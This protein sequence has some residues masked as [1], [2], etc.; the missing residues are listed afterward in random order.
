P[1]RRRAAPEASRHAQEGRR[2]R[3]PSA[4]HEETTRRR[5]ALTGVFIHPMI[6]ADLAI[7]NTSELLTVRGPAPRRGA[8]Q[9][10]LGI[11][12]HGCL[13]ARSGRIVFVGDER[14]YR[15]QVRLNRRGLEIDATGRTVLPGFVD[16]H[17]H[18]PFAGSR[19]AEFA[20]V[21]SGVSY[22]EIA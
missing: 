6:D 17:T 21:L 2:G 8:A 19:E 13:A 1:L 22:A 11:I 10:D 16:P 5:G 14:D 18:L 3:G 12:E 7:V 20:R 15:R 4:L 9:G